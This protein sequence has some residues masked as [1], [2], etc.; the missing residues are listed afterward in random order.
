MGNFNS[1]GDRIM[2]KRN[3]M[4]VETLSNKRF[5]E[6]A[7]ITEFLEQIHLLPDEVKNLKVYKSLPIEF[8]DEKRILL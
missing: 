5:D 7:G 1:F 3:R 4:L 8:V 6:E 2:S